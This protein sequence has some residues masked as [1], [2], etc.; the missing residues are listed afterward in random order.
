M[1]REND[2]GV[3][4][5][6]I[7]ARPGSEAGTLAGQSKTRKVGD[8]YREYCE[9]IDAGEHLDPDDY[10]AQF[11]SFQSSLGRLLRAHDYLEA[12]P[13][14]LDD[15][16]E[17]PWP[18]AGDTYLNFLLVHELG[19]GAFARVFLAKQTALGDRL[20][21]VKISRQGGAAEAKTLG[22]IQHPNVVPIHSIHADPR[23]GQTLVCMPY[24]GTATLHDVFD[25]LKTTNV[26]NAGGLIFRD[27]SR[28]PD[29][30]SPLAE[31]RHETTGDYVDALRGVAQKLAEALAYIHQQ[32]VCHLDL[33]PS[34]V[35]LSPA[36]EPLLLDF[37]L[38]SDAQWDRLVQGG[39]LPYMSPEQL[40]YFLGDGEKQSVGPSSD[41][42]SFGVLLYELA[43]GVHPFGPVALKAPHRSL[44]Q[45]LLERQTRG[46]QPVRKLNPNIDARLA[47]LIESCL[48]HE[49]QQ[50]PRSAAE[51][52]TDL[53]RQSR[54]FAQT[55]R[56]FARN[57]SKLLTLAIVG[58]LFIA[59]ASAIV[60]FAPPQ[61]ERQFTAAMRDYRDGRFTEAIQRLNIVIE[62][63]PKN[64]AAFFA[65]GRA[66]QKLGSE[67]STMY[68]L[69]IEDYDKSQKLAPDGKNLAAAGYCF[70][71]F[72]AS[73]VSAALL[74][75]RAAEDAG[76]VNSALLNNIAVCYE[77]SAAS[78]GEVR[79]YLDRAL[80]IQ[81]VCAPA[82]YNRAVCNLTL[83]NNHQG[84]LN[85]AAKNPGKKFSFDPEALKK[86]RDEA[87]ALA[88]ADFD[89]ALEIGPG[90]ADLYYHAARYHAMMSKQHLASKQMAI[91]L[92]RSAI[93][94]YNYS[95]S[96]K[97]VA[98]AQ[99]E[100]D[101]AYLAI[102]R[103]PLP[104]RPPTP[105]TRFVD[106]VNDVPAQ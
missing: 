96:P 42:F 24:L 14:L 11:P 8:A 101:P 73:K 62:R 34:N 58:G 81:P 19:Q 26:R 21:V 7:G 38:S 5:L 28:D 74:R 57:P 33:K 71:S 30:T 87:I 56:W 66:F 59:A 4:A 79:K 29:A 2:A 46:F 83:I 97:D 32:G 6:E 1:N 93:V 89:R 80:A 92:L 49:P 105:T 50:R 65:R 39:T 68:T 55:R 77:K 18:V 35:L 48:R 40:R 10:C 12:H 53:S 85:L 43:T 9:Q 82:Y 25:L 16:A 44:A 88:E 106:P 72:P 98:F 102:L 31:T 45:L 99:L 37:N 94:D 90:S 15:D 84:K 20:V 91:R 76:F 95:F 52:V 100:N 3:A 22:R 103:L 41:L 36:G 51:I 61:S 70:Q 60:V 78:K 75:Y 23:T 13:E 17:I 27:A 63:E 86:E 54:P 64:A 47:S 69:A 67:D 104:A